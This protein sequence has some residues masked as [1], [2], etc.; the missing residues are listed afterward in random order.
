MAQPVREEMMYIVAF[1][2]YFHYVVG[3]FATRVGAENYATEKRKQRWWQYRV[4][5]LKKP[6]IDHELQGR[7]YIV[8]FDTPLYC[9]VGPFDHAEAEKY[10]AEGPAKK[11][12]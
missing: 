5:E 11:V 4:V 10:A 2:N 6:S 12:R 7:P 3:P 9:V 1:D 8:V